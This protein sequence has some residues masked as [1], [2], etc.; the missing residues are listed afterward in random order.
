MAASAGP[1]RFQGTDE[2]H[3]RR[4]HPLV[5]LFRRWTIY[6]R[7]DLLWAARG[8]RAFAG[9]YLADA[10]IGAGAGAGVLLLAERFDGIGPWSTL[11]AVFMLGYAMA[12]DGLLGTFFGNNILFISRRLGRGQLDH[13]LV[14]PQPLWLA[15]LT[16]GFMPFSGS[17]ALVPGIALTAWAT[18]ALGLP[19]TAGWV[20][21]LA[22]NLVA[23]AAIVLAFCY[24]WGSLAFWAPRAAEEINSSTVRMV[25]QLKAFPLDGVGGV[26]LGSL[27]TLIPTG[28]V[29][30]Y[31]ARALLGL[32][33]S[34]LAAAGTPLAAVAFLALAAW[35][36]TTG[37][38]HYAR[39]GSQRYS[40]FGHR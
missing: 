4:H 15:L 12:A 26:L 19:V 23:S 29:A 16:E 2:A 18:H 14:Q 30:W 24:A 3:D 27:M 5:Q 17:G 8:L 39:T 20:A 33:R 32:D 40:S 1:A 31:P 10:I 6:A 35:I 13:V 9:Y 25:T 38:H 11:E 36:F 28:F 34:L 37:L 7:M 21:T 22:A